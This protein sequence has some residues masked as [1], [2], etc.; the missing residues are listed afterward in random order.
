MHLLALPGTARA[1]RL[2]VRELTRCRCCTVTLLQTR[3]QPLLLPSPWTCEHLQRPGLP[4]QLQLHLTG[5]QS[6]WCDCLGEAGGVCACL[7]SQHPS[8][9]LP[10][11]SFSQ[12]WVVSATKPPPHL[13]RGGR[14]QMTEYCVLHGEA[15]ICHC[16]SCE[17]HGLL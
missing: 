7:F 5:S 6:P 3:V 17:D 4:V 16:C 12:Q 8:V 15:Q 11:E 2:H 1:A 13:G 10:H 14:R 9:T